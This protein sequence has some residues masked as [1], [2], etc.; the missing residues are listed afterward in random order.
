MPPESCFGKWFSKPRRPTLAMKNSLRSFWS[1]SLMPR[2]R[3]PKRM[4]CA[5]VSH[6]K[7][8]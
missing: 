6:G 4:F 7:S 2:S 1:A 3:R 8:V 5:T